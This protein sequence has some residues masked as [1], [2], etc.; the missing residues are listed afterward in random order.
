MSVH[1]RRHPPHP[2]APEEQVSLALRGPARWEAPACLEL[3]G[4]AGGGKAAAE[5]AAIPSL[6]FCLASVSLATGA[7]EAL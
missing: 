1:T 2:Q 6:G 5:P 4:V 3:A 7:W